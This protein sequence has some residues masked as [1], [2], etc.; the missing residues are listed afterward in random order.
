MCLCNTFT[1]PTLTY[2]SESLPL[3][4][5]DESMLRTFERRVLRITYDPVTENC[6]WRSRY[7]HEV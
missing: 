5:A 1:G 7:N 6:I 3:K 4:R 2:R